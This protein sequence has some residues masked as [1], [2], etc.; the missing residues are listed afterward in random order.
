MSPSRT[1]LVSGASG[2][3]GTALVEHLRERGDT[4]LRLVRGGRPG[5]PEQV[6]WDPRAGELPRHG[7]D[8]VD[9]VVNLSGAPIGTRRWTSRY[10]T[11]IVESRTRA[12]H[13][14]A[15][16]IAD[17]PTPPALVQASAIGRYPDSGRA[18]LEESAGVDPSFLGHVVQTWESAAAPARRAGARVAFARTGIV[19]SPDGGAVPPLLRLIRF[20]VGGPM[21]SGDQLWS[22][23]TLVDEVRA[24]AHLIDSDVDGPVN[25]AAP[26]PA[27]NA[28]LT[29]ALARALRRPA[30][31]RA[32]AWALRLALDGFASELLSSRN[33]VPRVL[34]DSGFTFE[35]PDLESA[36]RWLTAG[37]R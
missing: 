31:V 11:E 6:P 24:L 28:E 2:L 17:R 1:V 23:I 35:H 5:G 18:P 21:G 19:L 20:G 7:L 26:A 37:A 32:P 27:T 9:V 14:L 34:I 22:W 10:R 15:T 36:V 16:W 30:A 12:S 13:L 3:I 25:L 29:G 4:V 33:V 8:D